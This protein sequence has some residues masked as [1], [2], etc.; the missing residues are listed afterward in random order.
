MYPEDTGADWSK[1]IP[2]REG[3]ATS[4]ELLTTQKSNRNLIDLPSPRHLFMPHLSPE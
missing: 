1:S 4:K 3:K 2:K